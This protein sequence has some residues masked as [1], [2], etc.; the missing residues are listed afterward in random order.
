MVSFLT[1][2]FGFALLMGVWFAV[3]ALA[4]KHSRCAPDQDMLEGHGCGAC[5]H[6]GAC[7]KTMKGTH[8]GAA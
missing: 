7:H 1:G 6:S 3:Q 2:I 4:R 8:H 5:D